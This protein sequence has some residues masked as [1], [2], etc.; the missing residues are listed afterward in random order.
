MPISNLRGNNE[1]KDIQSQIVGSVVD[2][3]VLHTVC[4]LRALG[5]VEFFKTLRE[6][7]L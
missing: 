7:D 3:V 5:E 2:H 4:Y 6:R 1:K